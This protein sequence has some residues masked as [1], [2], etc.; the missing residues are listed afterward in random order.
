MTVLKH[1]VDSVDTIPENLRP[2]YAQAGDKLS[3]IHI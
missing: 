2:L 3:L 1:E